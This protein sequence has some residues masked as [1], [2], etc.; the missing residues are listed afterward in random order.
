VD[1]IAERMSGSFRSSSS[2]SCKTSKHCLGLNEVN[3]C[4]LPAVA[5]MPAERSPLEAGRLR[6]EEKKDEL[7]RIRQPDVLEVCRRRQGNCGI[8]G[9]ECSTE[10][11]VGGTLRGHEQMF[12]CRPM[13]CQVGA[14]LSSIPMPSRARHPSIEPSPKTDPARHLRWIPRLCGSTSR[15]RPDD[16]LACPLC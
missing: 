13:S 14:F 7:Q 12:A 2:K 9:V 1:E 3:V 8:A 15:R 16:R 11:A 10:P 6:V 5:P 4:Q